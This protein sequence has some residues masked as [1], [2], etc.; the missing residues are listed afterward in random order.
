MV[1][2]TAVQLSSLAASIPC[3]DAA[4]CKIKLS[5]NLLFCHWHSLCSVSQMCAIWQVVLSSGE[6]IDYGVCVW[7]TGNSSRPLVQVQN[8]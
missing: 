5:M 6:R 2:H 4:G 8:P 7:S 1:M 3:A